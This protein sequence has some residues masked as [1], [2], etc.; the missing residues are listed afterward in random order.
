MAANNDEDAE[1][2]S[3][4]EKVANF[5]E[6]ARNEGVVM[7][8]LEYPAYYENGLVGIRCTADIGNREAFLSVPYKMMLTANKVK[9]NKA[10]ETLISNHPSCF[11]E[12]TTPMADHLLLTLGIFYEISQ[13]KW[14][15][16]Y[17]WL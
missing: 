14:S 1:V 17:P 12:E 15:Y 9:T 8:K 4:E 11:D 10:L 3:T 13:G 2:A 16:W 7:P 5:L 6:W